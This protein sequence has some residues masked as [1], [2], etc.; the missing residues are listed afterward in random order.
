MLALTLPALVL[1]GCKDKSTK[2]DPVVDGQGQ[3][4]NNNP[5]AQKLDLD[6][7]SKSR[8]FV[9]QS[10][11]FGAAEIKKYKM[12]EGTHKEVR[13]T[14]YSYY[15]SNGV[16]LK[17]ENKAKNLNEYCELFIE[18]QVTKNDG[19]KFKLKQGQE[20]LVGTVS[21]TKNN[22]SVTFTLM[23]Q[24]SFQHQYQLMCANVRNVEEL[25][26]HVDNIFSIMTQTGPAITPEPEEPEDMVKE[27]DVA[28]NGMN[29]EILGFI[30]SQSQ[31]QVSI[32][33]GIKS[34]ALSKNSEMS[35]V[36]IRFCE[37]KNDSCFTRWY[38]VMNGPKTK[39]LGDLV[40][41]E[42]FSRKEEVRAILNNLN[43]LRLEISVDKMIGEDPV[44][45]HV[46]ELSKYCKSSPESFMNIDTQQSG[47]SKSGF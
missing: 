39:V 15:I 3:G 26:D 32:N 47:C 2:N 5:W 20:L 28:Q 33:L 35:R 38:A 43:R 24:A 17:N 6:S 40:I 7:I 23:L 31:S 21:H 9:N 14:R 22:E 41:S 8:Y 36:F 27:V 30:Y 34:K 44:L 1:A 11:D 13:V 29:D 18:S 46:L 16:T 19:S 45:T 25:K 4:G 37:N 12:F 42:T 10:F